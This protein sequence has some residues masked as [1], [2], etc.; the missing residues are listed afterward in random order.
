MECPERVVPVIL[1]A[2]SAAGASWR[3]C[4]EPLPGY[5]TITVIHCIRYT[6]E[7]TKQ[8]SLGS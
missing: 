1:G 3:R 7:I 8:M 4:R 2:L 5:R 6:Y